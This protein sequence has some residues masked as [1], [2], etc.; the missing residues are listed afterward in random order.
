[1]TFDYPI[2]VL[3]LRGDDERR[4]AL[5]DSLDARGLHYELVYGVDGREGL[6]SK[7]ESMVDRKLAQSRL[8]RPLSDGE[9]ACALSHQQIYLE[10][11][12]RGLPGAVILEDDVRVGDDFADFMGAQAYRRS[13]MMLL[14]HHNTWVTGKASIRVTEKL[15]AYRIARPTYGTAGYALSRKAA[16][17]IVRR[18]TPIASTADWPCNIARLDCY[19]LSPQIVY[20][21]LDERPVSHIQE[22]RSLA[23][24]NLKAP[25]LSRFRGLLS[26]D[27]WFLRLAKRGSRRLS[28]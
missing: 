9:I 14:F 26:L 23:A 12:K 21:P 25:P 15:Q 2:F 22:G 3:T 19:A 10:I 16:S 4:T 11:M 27:Q 24:A 17:T 7:Y 6:P 28:D 20:H 1:M 8:W 13:D 18:S 5:I